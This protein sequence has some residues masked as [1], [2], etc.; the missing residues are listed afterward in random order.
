VSA[1]NELTDAEL[2]RLAQTTAD[3]ETVLSVYVDLD[4]RG[5]VEPRGRQSEIDSLLDGAHREIESRKHSHAQLLALRASL[6]RARE[7]LVPTGDWAKDARAYA[8]FLCEP[9]QLERGLRL[10]H[11]VA[12]QVVI[13]NSPFIA[14]LTEVG[15][16]G[17]IC[18]ALV[19]ERFARILRGSATQLREVVSFGDDVHGRH[20]K[21]GWSQARYQRSIADDIDSHLRHVARV[22]KDLLRTAPYQR[23]LIAC[24]QPLW[25]RLLDRLSNDVRQVLDEQRV[26]LDVGDATVED[27]VAAVQQPLAREQREHEDEVLARLREHVARDGDQ[28]AA[29]GLPAVLDALVQ[30]RVQTLLYDDTLHA[31]GVLCPRC[32]WIGVAGERC[33]VD[34]GELQR[35]DDVVD[36]ALRAATAQAAE[37]LPLHDRPELGPLGEIAATLRF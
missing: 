16:S 37:L 31:A 10:A 13:S 1:A 23:L 22:L 11:P 34:D 5:F 25:A 36:D 3:E 35:R 26:A 18:V 24:A 21:G 7:L 6:A 33:P 4:P 29:V 12:D 2:R 20:S 17:R 27:V 30:R 9:L 32:G 15:V 8:L 14:P 19:D 28:R